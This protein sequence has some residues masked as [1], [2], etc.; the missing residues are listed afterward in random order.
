[1]NWGLWRLHRLGETMVWRPGF[2][3]TRANP[4]CSTALSKPSRPSVQWKVIICFFTSIMAEIDLS[5]GTA[6]TNSLWMPWP[7]ST[8]WAGSCTWAQARPKPC[9]KSALPCWPDWSLCTH[10][11]TGLQAEPG[12]CPCLPLYSCLGAAAEDAPCARRGWMEAPC[13]VGWGSLVWSLWP[14][15]TPQQLHTLLLFHRQR[16]CKWQEDR[17]L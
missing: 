2:Y 9:Y 3:K 15:W 11:V 4:K 8:F 1:M 13:T 5:G 14:W 6:P 12:T 10:L 7:T 17:D 16:M